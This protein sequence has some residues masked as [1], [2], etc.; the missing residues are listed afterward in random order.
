MEKVYI[1]HARPEMPEIR[2]I[3]P[4]KTWHRP[5]NGQRQK[6]KAWKQNPSKRP[7]KNRK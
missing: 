5:R 1:I 6:R 2:L 4:K 3:E 7:L